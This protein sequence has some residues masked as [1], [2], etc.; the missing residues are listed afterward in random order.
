M[1][2]EAIGA[3]HLGG[4]RIPLHPTVL[5]SCCACVDAGRNGGGPRV[6]GARVQW[7]IAPKTAVMEALIV[8]A[9]H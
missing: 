5:F 1:M 7:A 6:T 4:T 3:K 8:S 9:Q 2:S